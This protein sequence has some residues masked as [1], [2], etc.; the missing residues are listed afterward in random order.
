MKFQKIRFLGGKLG[1]TVADEFAAETVGD[2]WLVVSPSGIF[3]RFGV[4]LD[5]DSAVKR[6]ASLQDLQKKLG[7]E[8]GMWVWEVIRGIDRSEG[9]LTTFQREKPDGTR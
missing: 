2:L 3:S 5:S 4:G 9:V 6:S 7:D 1:A 8:S